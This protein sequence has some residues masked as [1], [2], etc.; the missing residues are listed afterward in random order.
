MSDIN[1]SEESLL[2]KSGIPIA[3][4]LENVYI[5]IAGLIGAGK[6]TLATA[7]A[8]TLYNDSPTTVNYDNIPTAVF[9]QPP[10]GTVG[11]TEAEAR[12]KYGEVSIFRSSFRALKNTLSGR[13][14]QTL[15]K[16]IYRT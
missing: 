13:A 2:P 12:A 8:K 10:I 9:S 3:S 1:I 4:G 14:E 11:L 7:L 15:M 6:T 5:S 16:M